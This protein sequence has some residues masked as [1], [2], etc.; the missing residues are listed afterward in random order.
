[1]NKVRQSI[2]FGAMFAGNGLLRPCPARYVDNSST[3]GTFLPAATSE[4]MWGV[5]LLALEVR[6]MAGLSNL[7]YA[8]GFAEDLAE[9]MA[10]LTEAEVAQVLALLKDRMKDH[11]EEAA[12]QRGRRR[13]TAEGLAAF[14]VICVPV[15]QHI[16]DEVSII[17]RRRCYC[18]ACLDAHPVKPAPINSGPYA[19]RIISRFCER[20]RRRFACWMAGAKRDIVDLFGKRRGFRHC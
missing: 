6:K 1:M 2:N 12:E 18:V 9:R 19:L 16:T 8:L 10:L 5:Q 20:I 11:R 17:G 7:E 14:K 4:A 3:V 13:G 15:V